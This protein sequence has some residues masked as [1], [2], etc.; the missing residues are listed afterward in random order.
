VPPT[1]PHDPSTA[2]PGAAP[3]S[4]D[5]VTSPGPL[6]EDLDE[7]DVEDAPHEHHRYTKVHLLVLLLVALVLGYLVWSLVTRGTD[8]GTTAALALPTTLPSSDLPA[9]DRGAL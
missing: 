9:T 6:Q 8:D 4:S 1:T 2:A 3:S 5:D 7:H